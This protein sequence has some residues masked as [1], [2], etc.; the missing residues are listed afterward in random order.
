MSA[1]V[2]VSALPDCDFCAD[3]TP[4][5]FDGKTTIGPWANM[6]LH[7][8]TKYGVGLDTGK[9]QRLILRKGQNDRSAE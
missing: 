4:A 9:G 5:E 8:F 6:C 3:G 7:D 2:E 1:E